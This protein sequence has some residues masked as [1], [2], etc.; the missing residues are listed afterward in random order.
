MCCIRN[1]RRVHRVRVSTEAAGKGW[2]GA[3]GAVAGEKCLISRV[4]TKW[5]NVSK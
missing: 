4:Y 2:Y 5:L 1:Y 3:A